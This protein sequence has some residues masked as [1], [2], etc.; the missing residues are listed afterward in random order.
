MLTE[1]SIERLND[2]NDYRLA[3]ITLTTEI[4]T[5]PTP[6]SNAQV[7]IDLVIKELSLDVLKRDGL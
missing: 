5:S 3:F 7:Y 6:L 2:I 4:G 1:T